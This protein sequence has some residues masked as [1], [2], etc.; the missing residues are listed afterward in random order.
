VDW[1]SLVN[2]KTYSCREAK[3]S[4]YSYRLWPDGKPI[5]EA[6]LKDLKSMFHLIPKT[7]HEFYKK[8][9]SDPN[10]EDDHG[11]TQ[12]GDIGIYP[13]PEIF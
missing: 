11:R 5:A 1:F 13:P 7:H 9:T 3:G 10:S 4:P 6:K 2:L 12:G 8:L